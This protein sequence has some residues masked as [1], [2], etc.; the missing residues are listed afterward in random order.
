MRRLARHARPHVL[1]LGTRAHEQRVESGDDDEHE[2]ARLQCRNDAEPEHQI[3]VTVVQQTAARLR[4]RRVLSVER[5]QIFAQRRGV[6]RDARRH[7]RHL[8]RNAVDVREDDGDAGASLLL[9]DV[10]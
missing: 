2:R 1:T 7:V 3:A 4:D 10:Q 8:A 9:D 6:A 5:H